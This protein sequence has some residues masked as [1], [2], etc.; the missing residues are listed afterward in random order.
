MSWRLAWADNKSPVT[1]AELAQG[2]ALTVQSLGIG[3]WL[4]GT[5]V[6]AG[7]AGSAL[8][9]RGGSSGASWLARCASW[10]AGHG[11]RGLWDQ[12]EKAGG[13]ST[14]GL[15]CVLGPLPPCKYK[16]T[17]AYHAHANKTKLCYLLLPRKLR[18]TEEI[19]R[20]GL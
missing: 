11:I 10:L 1:W 4:P 14:S 17:H 19:L 16:Y 8:G 12:V 20:A 18:K 2:R 3:V 5:L 9:G 13:P 15:L 7:L 6:N